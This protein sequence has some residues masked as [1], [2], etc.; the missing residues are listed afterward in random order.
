[1]ECTGSLMADDKVGA[2]QS[3]LFVVVIENNHWLL[4]VLPPSE[5]VVDQSKVIVLLSVTQKLGSPLSLL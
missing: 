4:S 2:T 1:M 3:C 5:K